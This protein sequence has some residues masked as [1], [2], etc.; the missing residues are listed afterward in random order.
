MHRLRRLAALEGG[1]LDSWLETTRGCYRWNPALP[2]FVDVYE[3]E[4]LAAQAAAAPEGRGAR[5][6]GAG[7]RGTV[8]RPPAAGFSRGDLGRAPPDRTVCAV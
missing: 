3:L 5:R 2:C 7:H 8:P 4:R 6:H 1:A